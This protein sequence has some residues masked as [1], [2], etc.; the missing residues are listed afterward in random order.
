[1]KAKKTII[2]FDSF[3]NQLVL[4]DTETKRISI[5]KVTKL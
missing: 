4:R 2:Y 1:M 3:E 5:Y